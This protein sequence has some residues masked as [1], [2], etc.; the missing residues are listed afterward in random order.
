MI[1]ADVVD[2]LCMGPRG[3]GLAA[4]VAAAEA[5]LKAFVAEPNRELTRQMRP[6]R[7][8]VESWTMLLQ[9]RWGIEEDKFNTWTIGY[10]EQ[11]TSGPGPPTSSRPQNNAL[12]SRQDGESIPP[13]GIP[14]QRR[15]LP[16]LC[17][18]GRLV[19]SAAIG[20]AMQTNPCRRY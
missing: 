10:L 8:S 20:Y 5:G 13:S 4:G 18:A 2:I 11:L 6:V 7:A 16:Q 1:P 19:R 9:R 15:V 14:N 17:G 3:A 12:C